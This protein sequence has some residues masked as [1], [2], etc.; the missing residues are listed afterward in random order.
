MP[1]RLEQII[2]N[3]DLR[4]LVVPRTVAVAH[5]FNRAEGCETV[6][7]QSRCS[8]QGLVCFKSEHL[9]SEV[10]DNLW[11]EKSNYNN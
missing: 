8:H 1:A 3:H 5:R 7:K 4:V 11:H 10:F 2:T 6:L 9:D